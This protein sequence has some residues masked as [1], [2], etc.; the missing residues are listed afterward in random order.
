MPN[1][2]H[3]EDQRSW[4][5]L[6]RRQCVHQLP[7]MRRVFHHTWTCIS[8]AS[9]LKKCKQRHGR[10]WAIYLKQMFHS[11]APYQAD[12]TWSVSTFFSIL[13]LSPSLGDNSDIFGQINLTSG[14]SLPFHF[15]PLSLTYH[16]FKLIAS[17]AWTW[18]S[19]PVHKHWHDWV[20]GPED[21]S[22]VNFRWDSIW[23][24]FLFFDNQLLFSVNCHL[25]QYLPIKHLK[26]NKI[27]ITSWGSPQKL[28]WC[29]FATNNRWIGEVITGR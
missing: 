21:S 19:T 5:V 26:Q 15:S 11:L 4:I 23:R 20:M 18:W 27:L 22:L 25:L 13:S 10:K 6:L 29:V 16:P 28:L 3:F 7:P 24:I 9:D 1:C 2:K 12:K 8:S 17:A 14:C